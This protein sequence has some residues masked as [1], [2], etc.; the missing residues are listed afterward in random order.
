MRRMGALE[1]LILTAARTEVPGARRSE[2][3]LAGTWTIPAAVPAWPASAAPVASPE[4]PF[5]P[6]DP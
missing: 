4:R 5:F 6:L 2:I 3:D 1:L